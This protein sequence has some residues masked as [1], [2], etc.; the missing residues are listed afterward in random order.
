[1]LDWNTLQAQCLACDRCALCQTRQHVVFGDGN[2]EAKL[3]FVGE[4]PG[5]NEDI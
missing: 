2:P 3:L 5:Q 1:M 4:G